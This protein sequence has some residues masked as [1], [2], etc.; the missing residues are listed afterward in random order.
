MFITCAQ[1]MGFVTANGGD[2]A[3]VRACGL[4]LR[5]VGIAAAGSC[6]APIRILSLGIRRGLIPA[7]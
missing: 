1:T 4:S 2:N 7:A 5:L 3:A 6:F